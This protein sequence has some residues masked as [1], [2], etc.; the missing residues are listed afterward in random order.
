[1]KIKEL[2]SE[3]EKYPNQDAD[4]IVQLMVVLKKSDKIIPTLTKVTGISVPLDPN[5][6][7]KIALN[8]EVIEEDI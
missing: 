5:D 3:L 4:I 2:I 1:M 7:T 6:K 8:T